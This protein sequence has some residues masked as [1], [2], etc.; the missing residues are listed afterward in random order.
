M[1]VQVPVN[2]YFLGIYCDV[3][4]LQQP[5][6]AI[7]MLTPDSVPADQ[8]RSYAA[9]VDVLKSAVRGARRDPQRMR[10]AASSG[11]CLSL[12]GRGRAPVPGAGEGPNSGITVCGIVRASFAQCCCCRSADSARDDKG[13]VG[14]LRCANYKCA[15]DFAGVLLSK[16]GGLLPW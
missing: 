16:L 8:I 2:P 10:R 12:S 11:I 5:P 1:M 9:T 6:L 4:A 3:P 15:D 7:A 13:R 14:T